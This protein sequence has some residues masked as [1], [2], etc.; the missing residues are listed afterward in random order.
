MTGGSG[1]TSLP[2][3][4]T[5]GSVV[6]TSAIA[7]TGGTTTISGGTTTGGTGSTVQPYSVVKVTKGAL[8]YAFVNDGAA[9]TY[10]GPTPFSALSYST[11]GG[12]SPFV[13]AISIDGSGN[14]TVNRSKS[15]TGGTTYIGTLGS[16]ESQALNT[17]FV[18][19]SPA[20][21][22]GT[23]V[24][25]TTTSLTGIPTETLSS[26]IGSGIY[27]SVIARAGFY[28]GSSTLKS[29][30]DAIRG[31]AERIVRG[32]LTQSF[33]GHVHFVGSDLKVGGSTIDPTDPF[34]GLIASISGSN[35]AFDGLGKPHASAVIDVAGK[36]TVDLPLLSFPSAG[37]DVI[38]TLPAGTQLDVTNLTLS[39]NYFEVESAGQRGFVLASAVSIIR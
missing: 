24:D 2:I 31:P 9:S 13:D 14:V 5:N 11:S 30:V 7:T 3:T 22:P 26:T 10:S 34:Y 25:S 23:I 15:G 8:A 36:V 35:V 37:S 17:A 6:T 33:Q 39:G 38:S 4:I 16:S 27:T 19:A 12:S 29:L 28:N 21:L 1:S 20:T 18:N 32:T